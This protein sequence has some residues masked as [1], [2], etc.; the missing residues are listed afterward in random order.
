M[1]F[2]VGAILMEKREGLMERGLIS[3]NTSLVITYMFIEANYN[4]SLI[5]KSPDVKALLN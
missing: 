3:G 5:A 1:M 4:H 2:T